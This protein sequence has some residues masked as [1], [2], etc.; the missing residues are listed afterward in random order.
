MLDVVFLKMLLNSIN[1]YFVT[2]YFFSYKIL[3]S[4]EFGN[5]SK[6]K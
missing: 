3:D 2:I 5:C 6:T 4:M 1:Y